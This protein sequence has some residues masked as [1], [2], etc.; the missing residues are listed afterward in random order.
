MTATSDI[1]TFGMRAEAVE[2]LR[3]WPPGPLVELAVDGAEPWWRR[4]CCAEALAGRVPP[5]RAGDLLA[6]AF[7]EEAE[8]EV[9]G[10]LLD[11]LSVP[12]APHEGVLLDWLRTQSLA[13]QPY[14]MDLAIMR[15]RGVLADLSAA[16]ELAE[17]VAD[18]WRHRALVGQ[19]GLDV[20]V[21]RH[22]PRAVVGRLGATS[23]EELLTSGSTVGRRLAAQR[24][25]DDVTPALAD[26]CRSVA[27]AAY[28]QLITTDAHQAELQRLAERRG[29]GSVQYWALAVLA[30]RG[31]DI[32]PA[33]E[34][35]GR[36]R[37]ALPGVPDDVR[38]AI[39]DTYG[40]GQPDTDPLWLVERACMPPP[41]APDVAELLHIAVA[42][43]AN[44]ALLPREPV[45]A[46][47]WNDTG[48]GT[49]HVIS[50]AV[51]DVVVSTL[52][53]YVSGG[54]DVERESVGRALDALVAAGFQEIDDDLAATRFEGLAVYFFGNRQS[55][56]VY[57]LLF[58]WQD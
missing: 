57:D 28:E 39:L 33:W 56:R 55:L 3:A 10:A 4:R 14:D 15:A 45:S 26:P 21:E 53:P 48:W 34:E 40:P 31:S 32:R 22:G 37:V 23:A 41:G 54:P 20:L 35:L 11:V 38:A 44:A 7:D 9:R 52:G 16:D 42:V 24:L 8:T 13:G 25:V 46:G 12:G 29:G 43:L 50:T 49:Y 27:R 5:E 1:A 19:D 30:G 36:P 2:L 6:C 58:F 17:L 51:G 18:P 47:D